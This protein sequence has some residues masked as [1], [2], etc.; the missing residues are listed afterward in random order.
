VIAFLALTSAI[1]LAVTIVLF[2]LWACARIEIK[3]ARSEASS[4]REDAFWLQGQVN[5]MQAIA[6]HQITADPT[7]PLAGLKVVQEQLKR[8]GGRLS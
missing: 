1:L 3:G 6:E 7:D 5:S 8:M 4:A 2:Y